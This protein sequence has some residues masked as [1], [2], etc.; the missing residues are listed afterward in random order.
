MMRL[1]LL[2]TKAMAERT[3]QNQ[4][5]GKITLVR[6][7]DWWDTTVNRATSMTSP[8]TSHQVKRRL[9]LCDRLMRVLRVRLTHGKSVVMNT[10]WGHN[11]LTAPQTVLIDQSARKAPKMRPHQCCYLWMPLIN[12]AAPAPSRQA[13]LL[14]QVPP[15]K[16]PRHWFYMRI[17]IDVVST[18]YSVGGRAQCTRWLW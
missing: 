4:D 3:S 8:P 5:A 18:W 15:E 11:C 10:G 14:N 17:S 2:C 16:P 1:R 13:A 7:D 9:R 12:T 6:E